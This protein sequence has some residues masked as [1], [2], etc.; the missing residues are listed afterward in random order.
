MKN[1]QLIL[2]GILVSLVFPSN[3]AWSGGREGHGGDAIV[4][5]NISVEDAVIEGRMTIAGQQNIKS[6]T[7]LEKFLAEKTYYRGGLLKIIEKMPYQRALD[8]IFESFK[9]LPVFFDYL[10]TSNQQLGRVTHGIEASNGLFDVNDSGSV[11][12]PDEGCSQI[13]SMVRRVD[14]LSYDSNVFSQYSEADEAISQAHEVIYFIKQKIWEKRKRQYGDF[15]QDKPLSS[16]STQILL[17]KILVAQLS[18]EEIKQQLEQ[19]EFGEF[20]TAA[21]I[22]EYM[23]NNQVIERMDEMERVLDTLLQT[24]RDASKVRSDKRRLISLLP[25]KLKQRIFGL[26]RELE[27]LGNQV[28]HNIFEIKDFASHTTFGGLTFA[29]I[30]ISIDPLHLIISEKKLLVAKKK[31]E[32]IIERTHQ[33][34]EKVRKISE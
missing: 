12:V 31:I 11:I 2:F 32:A 22:L 13:Q 19:N 1:K 9:G 5:F 20:S 34:L 24:V 7:P 23:D 21:Q 29:T 33:E 8:A 28:N 10:N 6:A 27:E 18:P 25:L 15:F 30:P 14:E 3:S 17:T 26:A 4:C 16:V